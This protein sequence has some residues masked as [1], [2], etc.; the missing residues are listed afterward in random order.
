MIVFK[1]LTIIRTTDLIALRTRTKTV[2]SLLFTFCDLVSILHA[3]RR[4]NSARLTSSSSQ[5]FPYTAIIIISKNR[6]SIF[7]K[8]MG[9]CVYEY[10]FYAR[11]VT[12]SNST[13]NMYVLEYMGDPHLR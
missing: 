7:R 2:A 9:V 5:N 11:V 13:T 1:F 6:L 10:V 4:P 3:P 12:F 8:K